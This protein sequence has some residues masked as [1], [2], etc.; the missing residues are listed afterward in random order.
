MKKVYILFL[1]LIGAI[2]FITLFFFYSI[3]Q[4]QVNFQKS[5]LSEQGNKCVL[6]LEKVSSTFENQINYIL[7]SDSLSSLFD[8]PKE[9]NQ[10]IRKLELLYTSFP[11]LISNITVLDNEKRAFN[12]LR[13]KKLDFITDFYT[14]HTQKKL[15]KEA[16]VEYEN[17]QYQY[18]QPVFEN[19]VVIANIILGINYADLRIPMCRLRGPGPAGGR[20]GRSHGPVRPVR[21]SDAP[22]GRGCL[23]TV[24]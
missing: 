16:T 21:R 6:Q 8:S 14:S 1:S 23:P 2:L 12:L 18:I 13:D 11:T 4:K 24:L 10:I 5:I 20:T 19:N 17:E 7:Y 15:Y 9:N 22:L 3:S